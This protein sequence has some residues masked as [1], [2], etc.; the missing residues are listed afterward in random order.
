LH[1]ADHQ[2]HSEGIL[3]LSYVA[4]GLYVLPR[5]CCQ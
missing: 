5:G 1:L 4:A 2:Q 3:L